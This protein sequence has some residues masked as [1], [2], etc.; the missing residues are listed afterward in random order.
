MKRVL[1]VGGGAY[2]VPLIKRIRELGYEA[3]CVD[4]NGKAPGFK[5]ANGYRCIDILDE[6]ECLTYARELRIDGIATY[7]AT[8]TLPTVSY[9]GEVLGLPILP[10][11]TARIACNKYRIKKALVDGGCN[12]KGEI[13]A[14][15][16]EKEAHNNIPEFPCVIKPSDGSGSKGVSI[17]REEQQYESAVRE[18]FDSARFGEIYTEQYIEGDEYSVETFVHKAK[19]YIYAIVK[20]TFERHDQTNTGIAYG[21]KTPPGIDEEKE[22]EIIREIK[23]AISILNINMGSV[24]FDV[25]ISKEDGKAYIIDCGIRIGQ[26]LIGSHIVPLSR[27]VSEMDMYI[28]QV[29]GIEIDPKPKCHKNIATRLLIAEPGVIKEILSMETFIGKNNIIDI[30]MRKKVG[31]IQRT[32]TDKSDNCGWVICGGEDP[33]DA[34]QNAENARIMLLPNII[35]E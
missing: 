5:E 24:N 30:V 19:A 33:E 31:D 16:D 9:I 1:V 21:H 20:T 8:I 6:K 14:F 35:T 15:H 28:S 18:G 13:I 10:M 29:L 17:V 23:K 11:D 7:G 2:Q 12:T 3:Y 34:E 25:I 26:N 22:Q 32:Y 27:G 4:R